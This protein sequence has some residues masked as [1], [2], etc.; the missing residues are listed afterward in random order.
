MFGGRLSS[1]FSLS[2]PLSPV[3]SR[4]CSLFANGGIT[5]AIADK[6]ASIIAAVNNAGKRMRRNGR[7][8]QVYRWGTASAVGERI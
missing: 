6:N 3:H 8:S 4:L 5:I 1:S 7:V 2:I